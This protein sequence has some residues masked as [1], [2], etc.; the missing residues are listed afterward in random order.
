[1]IL[2][3]VQIS[4]PVLAGLGI[5]KI[6]SLRTEGKESLIK[7]IRNSAVGF[8]LLFVIAVLSGSSISDWFISR[9][10]DH[11]AGIQNKQ[12]AQQFTV[13]A[14]YMGDMFKS[15][16]WFAL[17]F[18]ALASWTANIYLKEKISADFFVLVLIIFLI[19]DLWRIDSRGARYVDNPDI[20]NM[21]NPHP[22]Y[23]TA[24]KNQNDKDPFRIL[25][26]K[27]DGSAGSFN[28]NGNF[29]AYY[30]LEDFYGYSGAKPRAIQDIIEVVGPVNPLLWRM[31]NVKYIIT[32]NMVQMEGFKAVYTSEQSFVYEN[33][34]VL[35]RA[36]L[37][38]QVEKTSEMNFL[39]MIKNSS[40]DPKEKAFIHD[41]DLKVDP[42]DSAAAAKITGYTEDRITLD[43]K[44]S[45][46][47]FLFLSSTYLPGW[48]ALIDGNETSVYKVNHGYSGV[49]IPAGEHKV[50]F[51]YAPES[52]FISKN[53]SLILS[54][55]VMLGLVLSIF[56][57]MK[58]RNLLQEQK[59]KHS[60][61]R[62]DRTHEVF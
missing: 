39:N 20:K 11:A 5:M 47:N 26:L 19:I 55:L 35:P 6:I 28:N 31:M 54:S 16:L 57:E 27:Q 24:I 37:V 18:L 44:A 51:R 38:N 58:K 29:H 48:K 36:Y 2:H 1:M 22:D 62:T 41:S 8:T 43:V 14:E 25:N 50:E 23:V 10:N 34:N 60:G 53:V 40:F 17:A 49:V 9:V 56:F 61:E 12:L 30:L 46:N 59:L 15:D 21:F 42:L 13:L 32:G 3:L 33:Q 45:G 7:V 52:F 4:F